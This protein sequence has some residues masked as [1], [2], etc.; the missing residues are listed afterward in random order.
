MPT[1]TDIVKIKA[2]LL[3]LSKRYDLPVDSIADKI[4]L[5]HDVSYNKRVIEYLDTNTFGKY[6]LKVSNLK[7]LQVVDKLDDNKVPGG[8]SGLFNVR[9]QIGVLMLGL[10]AAGGDTTQSK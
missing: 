2:L 5:I 1:D 3:K 9:I 6:F 10:K 8:G 7:L 4:E